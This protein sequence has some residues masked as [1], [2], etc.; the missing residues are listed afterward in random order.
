M[1]DKLG[2]RMKAYEAVATAPRL[3]SRLPIYARIDG[4]SFSSFTRDMLRPFDERMSALMVETA[5]F[6]IEET[7]ALCAYTQSDEISLLFQ[8]EG[9][10]QQ[11]F[12]DGRFF[13]LTSQLAAL[14]TARFL[15][16]ALETWPAKCARK[17]PSFD[18]RVFQ[19]PSRAE[20]ANAIL[21]RT[22]DA[23][24]NAI[25]MAA[26]AR[27]SHAFLQGKGCQELRL[28]LAENGYPIEALPA[29]FRF[30]T[31]LFRRKIVRP[32]TPDEISS[33]PERHRPLH[34][35]EVERTSIVTGDMPPFRLVAN[36]EAVLFG[37]AEPD[38]I[39]CEAETV[40][41]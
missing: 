22:L 23:E 25:S 2:D 28:M 19:L 1:D 40:A 27:F 18:A 4:R 35:D 17:L 14:A 21:W 3:D 32:L 20:A 30:G 31:F 6:L 36:R 38:I 41:A 5:R 11:M 33:I 13:K 16:G 7:G 9:E 26:H 29:S 12:F 37:D 15:K 8:T 10:H 24:R 34:N 39:V